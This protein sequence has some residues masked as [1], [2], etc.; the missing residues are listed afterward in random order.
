MNNWIFDQ[1][2]P[3][4]FTYD[5]SSRLAR[6]TLYLFCSTTITYRSFLDVMRVPKCLLKKSMHFSGSNISRVATSVQSAMRHPSAG[7]AAP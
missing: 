6:I 4:L 3:A 7:D 5:F 1:T 2:D